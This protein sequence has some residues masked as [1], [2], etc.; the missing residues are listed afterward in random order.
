MKLGSSGAASFANAMMNGPKLNNLEAAKKALYRRGDPDPG[1]RK[2]NNLEKAR[3]ALQA[4]SLKK[5]VDSG[6]FKEMMRE[7]AEKPLYKQEYNATWNG[8]PWD[9]S[10]SGPVK[11][12]EDYRKKV[13]DRTL[14]M[15]YE[16]REKASHP[17]YMV[18]KRKARF[19]S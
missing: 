12:D 4:S 13:M 6:V 3:W 14:N 10:T 19:R 2:E 7:M 5:K 11:K 16:Q 15:A 18:R 1:E 17:I 9:G 8:K